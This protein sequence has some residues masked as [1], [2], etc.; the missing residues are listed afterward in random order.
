MNNDTT[1]ENVWQYEA[2]EY[3]SLFPAEERIFKKLLHPQMRVLE[4]GCGS[5]RV[6]LPLQQLDI[7]LFA[8]DLS[9]MGLRILESIVDHNGTIILQA[10]ARSLPFED[11][12]FE[13]V[14]FSFMGLISC[15]RS[16]GAS[17]P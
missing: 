8:C 15:T 1:L 5:G 2:R 10:D 6:S 17:R 3:F 16:L 14:V 11:S 7:S 12:S 9:W 13:A 4:I